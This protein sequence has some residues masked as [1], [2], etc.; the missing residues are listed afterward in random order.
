ME[1]PGDQS[2]DM[3]LPIAAR[4]HGYSVIYDPDAVAVERTAKSVLEE[5]QRKV[6][7]IA[8]GLNGVVFALRCARQK[9]GKIS[10]AP[11]S[12]VFVVLQMVCKKLFRY[13]SFPALFIM[14]WLGLLTPPGI[15]FGATLVM[16]S[17]LLLCILVTILAPSGKRIFRPWPDLSYLL[18]MAWAGCAGFWIFITGKT[19]SHWKS[20]R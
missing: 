16:W 12:Q 17:G 11:G 7:I 6:R 18:A 3:I 8:R 19:M 9:G 13:L 14:L 15:T 10:S 20:H 5:Y 4:L 1:L 2:N